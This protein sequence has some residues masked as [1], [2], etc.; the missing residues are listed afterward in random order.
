MAYNSFKR[1]VWLVNLVYRNEGMKLK[2]I[3]VE[4]KKD[5]AVSGGEDLSRK[6]FCNYRNAIRE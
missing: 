6:N 4:W 5:L 3:S 1:Y 2:E